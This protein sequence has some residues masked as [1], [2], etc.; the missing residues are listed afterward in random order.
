MLLMEYDYLK[1]PFDL[2]KMELL[3]RLPLV[4]KLFDLE[5]LF[6]LINLSDIICCL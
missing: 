5:K 4:L 2:Q 1:Y 3:L 6:L